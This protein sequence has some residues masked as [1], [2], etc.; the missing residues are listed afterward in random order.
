MFSH[1]FSYILTI[2]SQKNHF[3]NNCSP[4]RAKG[5]MM[6][7]AS[8]RWS[9]QISSFQTS[10]FIKISPHSNWYHV[11]SNS[12][13]YNLNSI[14]IYLNIFHSGQE[15]VPHGSLTDRYCLTLWAMVGLRL[16]LCLL[17][18]KGKPHAPQLEV[19]SSC[20]RHMPNN[21]HSASIYDL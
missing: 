16:L 5:I 8:N 1:K 19:R 7:H 6:P 10:S 15:I 14:H 4:T 17:G 2:R 11:Q 3:S 9:H 13:K 18:V 20:A 12:C 21:M